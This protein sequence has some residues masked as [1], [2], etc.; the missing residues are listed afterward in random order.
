MP[1]YVFLSQA[2]RCQNT[3]HHL[4]IPGVKSS[5][6]SSVLLPKSLDFLLA[7]SALPAMLLLQKQQYF[8]SLKTELKIQHLVSR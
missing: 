4:Q 1:F 3:H 8:L 6:L 5:Q 7:T 2:L